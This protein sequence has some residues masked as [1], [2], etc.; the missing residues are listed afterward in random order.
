MEN[1]PTTARRLFIFATLFLALDRAV[2]LSPVPQPP[3]PPDI[4][5]TIGL[6][7]TSL[8]TVLSVYRAY[9]LAAV[10]TQ[11]TCSPTMKD[12]ESWR[13]K[14]F[15][16][17]SRNMVCSELPGVLVDASWVN[18]AQQLINI[19]I[20]FSSRT[21][22][23]MKLRIQQFVRELEGS[24]TQNP[25]VMNLTQDTWSPEHSSSRIK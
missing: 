24:L 19:D 8:D 22:P 3:I 20:V 13:Q 2:A 5:L 17:S 1:A 12:Y 10:R 7:D 11:L 23:S 9:E 16:P 14:G 21:L 25:S 15:E 4:R 18:I 6:R